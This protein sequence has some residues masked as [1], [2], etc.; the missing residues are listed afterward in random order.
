MSKITAPLSIEPGTLPRMSLRSELR[1][2][3]D[4][5]WS[6]NLSVSVDEHQIEWCMHHVPRQYHALLRAQSSPNKLSLINSPRYLYRTVFES[7]AAAALALRSRHEGKRKVLFLCLIDRLEAQVTEM[8]D[9][10]NGLCGCFN[11]CSTCKFNIADA[12]IQYWFIYGCRACRFRYSSV[13]RRVQVLIS[14]PYK[15]PTRL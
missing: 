2:I 9:W 7:A 4:G 11:D 14:W 10:Q 5:S 6:P 12:S 15:Y 1:D 13:M 3:I 8:S